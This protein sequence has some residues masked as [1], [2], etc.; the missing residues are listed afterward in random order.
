MWNGTGGYGSLRSSLKRLESRS[1]SGQNQPDDKKGSSG[2]PNLLSDADNLGEITNARDAFRKVRKTARDLDAN[3]EISH[4]KCEAQTWRYC[5]KL[6]CRVIGGQERNLSDIDLHCLQQ[7]FGVPISP[8]L[9]EQTAQELRSSTSDQLEAELPTVLKLQSVESTKYSDPC[10]STIACLV[11]LAESI[12]HLFSDD[13]A[14]A[15]T[16]RRIGLQLRHLVDVHR[17]S[18][19]ASF[20]ADQDRQPNSAQSVEPGSPGLAPK[21]S[22]DDVKSE[23]MKLIGLENVK[24]DFV[25]ISNLI[26]VRQLRMQHGLGIDPFSLHLVFTGNPGTGKTTVARLLARAYRALGVLNKGHLIEVDRSGLVGQYI[27]HTAQKTKEVVRSALDGVLFIDEAY[28]LDGEGKDFGPEAINTLLKL[29]EDHRDRLIVIVAGYTERMGKFLATN[30]GLKSRF[31][32]FV[33]F[34]DYTAAEMLQIFDFMLQR[35]E[36]QATEEALQTAEKALSIVCIDKDEHFGNGRL[37][38]NLFER[39]LQE[40]ANRLATNVEPTR[41]QL[42]TI[43]QSDVEGALTGAFTQK[44]PSKPADEP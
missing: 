37:V 9:F 29:M 22:L 1:L 5:L 35:A 20:K 16:P 14:F 17:E 31:N 19:S 21:E 7:I 39:V 11:T 41:V 32:K 23:L 33:H 12:T 3:S 2:V 15:G 18:V 25:S 43:E 38:R 26:R 40:Q 34:D 6:S 42:L 27:G 30:P 44:P 8:D 10:D 24:N 28:A 13:E 36:Y 4:E